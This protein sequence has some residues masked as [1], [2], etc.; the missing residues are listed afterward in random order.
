MNSPSLKICHISIIT[1]IS[2]AVKNEL[3]ISK[4]KIKESAVA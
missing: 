1:L 3:Y 2:L 4:E